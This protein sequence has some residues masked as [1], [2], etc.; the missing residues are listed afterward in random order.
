APCRRDTPGPTFGARVRSMRT[1]RHVGEP[2]RCRVDMSGTLRLESLGAL[3]LHGPQGEI[4][5]R[6]RKELVL[7]VYLA[8]HAPRPVRRAERFRVWLEAERAR[9]DR[10]RDACFERLVA[11]HESAADW[12]G[13]A[14]AARRWAEVCAWTSGRTAG[15]S[16]RSRSTAAWATRWRTRRRSR[17]D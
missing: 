11:E 1:A 17:R 9:L 16:R 6:R 12:A 5:P 3:R 7:L 2:G 10:I 13:M 4:L 15:S 14:R 8:A